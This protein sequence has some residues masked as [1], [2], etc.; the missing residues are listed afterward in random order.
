LHYE[1]DFAQAGVELRRALEL[2]P[3]DGV[4]R[5][6]Y[7]HY[8]LSLNRSHESVSESRRAAEYD[9]FNAGYTACFGW[10]NLYADGYDQAIKT[11]RLAL[12]M[13]PGN[14]FASLVLGW[15]YEQQHRYDEAVAAFRR[16]PESSF[17]NASLA[18][19]LA[20]SGKQ[21]EAV[22]LLGRLLEQARSSYVSAYEL[23]LVY[24]ALGD[25][26]STYQWLER[27]VDER[28]G[29]VIHIGWDPRL[30]PLRSDPRFKSILRRVGLPS[31]GLARS[32]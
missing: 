8:L 9:P 28:S 19:A 2:D 1:F 15:G 29:Y 23:A 30:K 18:R 7:A 21:R 27:A 14:G 16:A 10:H 11:A 32:Y 12:S 17:R 6:Y 13:D 26:E 25:Q 4:T 24:Q 20:Q 3:S 22:E 5:H 31:I